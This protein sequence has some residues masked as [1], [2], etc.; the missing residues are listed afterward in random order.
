MYSLKV[1]GLSLRILDNFIK[2]GAFLKI[3][4]NINSNSF[5]N[6]SSSYISE[7]DINTLIGWSNFFCPNAK[8]LFEIDLLIVFFTRDFFI[9]V[10]LLNIFGLAVI[11]PE[12]RLSYSSSSHLALTTLS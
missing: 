5:K 10:K 11:I 2:L 3:F 12:I 1:F 8:F 7:S 6:S 9:P 4:F